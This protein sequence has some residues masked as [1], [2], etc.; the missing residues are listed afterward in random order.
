MNLVELIEH[1]A[2]QA[3]QRSKLS[4]ATITETIRKRQLEI[5]KNGKPI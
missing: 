1:L 3:V 2:Q 4:S 5:A